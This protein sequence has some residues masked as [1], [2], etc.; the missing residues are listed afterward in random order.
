M[1]TN[2]A[3]FLLDVVDTGAEILSVLDDIVEVDRYSAITNNNCVPLFDN[4]S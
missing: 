4:N 2:F 1:S 3:F